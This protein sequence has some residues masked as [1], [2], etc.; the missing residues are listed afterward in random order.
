MTECYPA[1]VQR[2]VKACV[3][4]GDVAEARRLYSEMA[5]SGA[6]LVTQADALAMLAAT[7]GLCHE[8]GIEVRSPCSHCACLRLA[9]RIYGQGLQAIGPRD[10]SQPLQASPRSDRRQPRL[11]APHHTLPTAAQFGGGCCAQDL[12]ADL[13]PLPQLDAAAV[14]RLEN[15]T[16][17]SAARPLRGDITPGGGASA[18]AA[19]ADGE[20]GLDALSLSACT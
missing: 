8:A 16:A 1:D 14:S 6:P 10:C 17:A 15:A 7:H 18:P 4:S 3:A 12:A 9:I 2:L 5:A 20:P 19:T 11:E 13:P